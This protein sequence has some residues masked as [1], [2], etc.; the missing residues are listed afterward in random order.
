MSVKYYDIGVNLFSKQF[1]KDKK[2]PTDIMISCKEKDIGMI[3]IS[4]NMTESYKTQL[5]VEFANAAIVPYPVYGIVGIHPHSADSAKKED[6]NILK[7][8]VHKIPQIVALGECGLDYDRNFSTKENQ[9][10]CFEKQICLAEELNLP[11]YL[12]ERKAVSDFVK[13]FKNHSEICKKSVIHCFTGDRATL[14]KYIDM[15]FSIGITGWIC[16]DRRAKDLREA[17]KSLPLDKVMIETDS[18]F[19]TPMNKGLS[20]VNYPWNVKYVAEDLAKYMSVSVEELIKAAKDNTEKFF[21]IK[22]E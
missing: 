18:P 5:F 12:H 19:L 20:R 11:L 8:Y 9:I 7:E 6:F 16:D 2:K 3:V 4:N 14:E 17:V 22:G 15:G 13:R 10:R 1:Q 21:N